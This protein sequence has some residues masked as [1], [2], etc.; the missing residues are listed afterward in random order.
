MTRC[1]GACKPLPVAGV[2]RYGT[3]LLDLMVGEP[4]AY[5]TGLRLKATGPSGTVC[6]SPITKG[7]MS[8][9]A[10]ANRGC[11]SWKP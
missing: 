7:S 11:S 1:L 9:S 8:M 10:G 5:A 2:G 3:T 6:N 4:V